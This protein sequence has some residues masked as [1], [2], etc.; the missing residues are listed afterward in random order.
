MKHKLLVIL[1][2]A[3]MASCAE[4]EFDREIFVYFNDFETGDYTGID[5]VYI[6]EFDDS[7][8]MGNFN[9][10]GFSLKL[11]DLPDHDY[12]KLTFNLYIHD[13]WEGN[14]NDSGSGELDHDAWILE[15]DPDKKI[16]PAE[17]IYFETTFSNGLCIPGWCFNQSYPNEFPFNQEARALALS[18]NMQGWCLWQTS[19]I[20]TSVYRIEKVFP[21]TRSSTVLAFYD[22]LKTDDSFDPICDESW[23]L[24][25]LSISILTTK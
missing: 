21:H 2:L 22:R 9:N 4:P 18:R 13:S 16:S 6:S 1:V 7:K 12:I 25:N 17:K 11:N 24:D 3:I 15:F 20:G 19:P 10:S 5:S 23:S 8:V 14:S